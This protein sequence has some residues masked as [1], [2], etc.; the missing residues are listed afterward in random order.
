[1]MELKVCSPTQRGDLCEFRQLGEFHIPTV[2]PIEGAA[3]RI[4]GELCE[5]AG[6]TAPNERLRRP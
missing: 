3:R 5:V 4:A 1:M 2:L 6:A